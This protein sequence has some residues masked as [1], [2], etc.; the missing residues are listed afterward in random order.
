MLVSGDQPYSA[1]SGSDQAPPISLSALK[2][3][4]ITAS[5]AVLEAA[6]RRLTRDCLSIEVEKRRKTFHA[7]F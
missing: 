7:F 2:R 4:V 5:R 3:P 1:G 6:S